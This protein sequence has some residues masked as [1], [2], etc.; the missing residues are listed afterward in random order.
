MRKLKPYMPQQEIAVMDFVF[1][2]M[3]LSCWVLEFGAGGS[4][5][6]WGQVVNNWLSIEHNRDWFDRV[7]ESYGTIPIALVSDN[8]FDAY[9]AP[10]RFEN[11]N[12]GTKWDVILVDGLYRVECVKKSPQWL[13]QD[14]I[15]I[16]HDASRPEY[17]EALRVYPH[18]LHLTRGNGKANGLAVM[19]R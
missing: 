2:A 12:Y 19:W 13:A 18:T 8:D 10:A 4:T 11:V 15:V 14:G 5:L 1:H 17:A 7:T 6:R 3:K 16:L 9:S